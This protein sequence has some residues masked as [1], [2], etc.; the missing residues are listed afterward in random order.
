MHDKPLPAS[1]LPP[2]TPL[3]STASNSSLTADDQ[4]SQF[5][6]MDVQFIQVSPWL[7]DKR[8]CEAPPGRPE[9]VEWNRHLVK[10]EVDLTTGFAD[11]YPIL[12]AN[13]GEMP[14]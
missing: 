7:E 5:L 4:L 11:G 14:I 6:K 12:I 3:T 9:E 13:E 2:T 8:I 1:L 10:K